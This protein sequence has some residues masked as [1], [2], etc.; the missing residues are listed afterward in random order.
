MLASGFRTLTAYLNILRILCDCREKHYLCAI[1]DRIMS[2]AIRNIPVLTGETA[3]RFV[4]EAEERERNPRKQ[5]L[6][7]SFEEIDKIQERSREYL[8][9]HNGRAPF[10]N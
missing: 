9:K 1:N 8:K 10:S 2:L 6:S 7:V 3:E 5:R 4:L